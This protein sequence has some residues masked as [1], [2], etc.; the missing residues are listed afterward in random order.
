MALRFATWNV[1]SIRARLD[2]V[3]TWLDQHEPDVLCLQETKVEDNLFPRVPFLELGYT[4]TLHGGRALCGVATMSK[5][6]PTEVH[7]GFRE[8]PADRQPRLLECV[9]DGVR[10]FNLYAPNGTELGSEAFAY[11]LEWFARL[12]A[13]LDARCDPGQPIL[14]MG[15]FNIAPDDR[16]VWDPQLLRGRMLFTDEEHA[17]LANLLGFGLHDAF[18]RLENGPGHFTWFDYRTG[19]FG[20][21]EGLR[22]DLALASAGLIDRV[23]AVTHDH[24]P[25]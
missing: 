10:I 25:R 3:L 15:D 21:N 2:H 14:L 22:I 18:R 4:V 13:Q 1:N 8:A 7:A 20:R 12:R 5:R 23:V 24:T 16:D 19:G 9:V 17:A 11:K 6:K